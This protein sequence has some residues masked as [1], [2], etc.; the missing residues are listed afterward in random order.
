MMQ[1]EF[2]TSAL[3]PCFGRAEAAISSNPAVRQI[4]AGLCGGCVTVGVSLNWH[5]RTHC[6][7]SSWARRKTWVETAAVKCGLWWPK[8]TLVS[9]FLSFFCFL[10]SKRFLF[11]S[12]Q[13]HKWLQQEQTWMNGKVS[14]FCRSTG[15]GLNAASYLQINPVGETLTRLRRR[16][17]YSCVW[18]HHVVETIQT[19]RFKLKHIIIMLTQRFG[20]S[21]LNLFRQRS[22]HFPINC[23]VKCLMQRPPPPE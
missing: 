21:K 7:K 2:C 17:V 4:T 22:I 10:S 9:T 12:Q 1:G 3:L 11:F 23:P 14:I 8:V 15:R 20:S 5:N 19:S 6:V 13:Q 18:H 16:D